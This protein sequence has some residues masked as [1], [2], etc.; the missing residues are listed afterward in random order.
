MDNEF[1]YENR[2]IPTNNR[3]PKNKR[4]PDNKKKKGKKKKS[5]L[6]KIAFRILIILIILIVV[7]V[8]V[9]VGY[10]YNKLSKLDYQANGLDNVEV[11]EG[12]ENSGYLNIALFG[13]DARSNNYNGGSGSDSIMVISINEKTKEVKMA[14]V[15]RDSYLC[16]ED[17]QYTKITDTY[18]KYGPEKTVS[19]L[20]KNLDLDISEYVTINFEVVADVVNYVGGVQVTIGNA[21]L[22]YINGYIDESSHVTG[23]KS[24]HIEKAG[25][26]NL[27]GIQALAYARIRYVGTDVN[28]AERQREVLMKAFDKVKKMNAVKLNGLVDKILPKV[29]TTLDKSEIIN[30][31]L[32]VT[33]YNIT[34]SIGFPYNWANYQPSG[35]YYLAPRNLEE[36]VIKLHQELF[37]KED[38]KVSNDLKKISDNLINKTGIK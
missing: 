30:L 28:R 20:N 2:K 4:K 15:L 29:K 14:S 33:Q 8:G 23:I 24:S 38:Y 36:N 11:N 32:G 10:V 27:D 6:L 9:L 7:V 12:V 18:R 21:D 31:A 17:N 25:T 22:Q 3:I 35:I 26:Y 5:P 16:Y 37:E 13:I 1:I 34:A 19:V